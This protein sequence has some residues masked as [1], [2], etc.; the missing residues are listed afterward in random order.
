MDISIIIVNWN[1]KDLLQACLDSIR[2]DGLSVEIIVVD[3][4]STDGSPDMVR[5]H[6]PRVQLIEPGE[7]VG[8]TRGNNIG[9]EASQGRYVFLLNPDTEI[10]GDALNLMAAYMDNHPQVGVVGPQLL[11]DDGSVQSSRRRFPTVWTAIFESTWLQPYAPRQILDRYYVLDRSDNETLHVDW[12]QGAAIFARREVFDQVGLLDEG[13]FMYSE[14]MD[15][16]RRVKAP[17]W[18]VVYYPEAQIIHYGGKS[19]EQVVAQRDIYFHTSKLRYFRKHHG[20]WFACG[21]RWFL[22][23]N[24]VWQLVLESVKAL[25]GHKREMRIKRIDAYRQVLRSGLKES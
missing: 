24:Y 25:L 15:W 23:G 22:L 18:E 13:F 5:E 8:F 4:A 14:E 20:K 7:N 11:N 2:S 21:L 1:V 17:G 9:I 16:Q 3:S 10:V 12:V 6:F 19:S